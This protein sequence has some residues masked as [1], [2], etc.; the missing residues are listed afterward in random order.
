MAALA[1][2]DAFAYIYDQAG[3]PAPDVLVVLKRV[4]DASGNPILLGPKTT[5]TDSAGA[6][7]FTLPELGTAFIS[8]RA[9]A[10]WNCP[11]GRAF[12]VPPGPSGEL[13]PDFSLPASTLVEPPL[14][15]VGDVLSIPKASATQDGYLSAADFAAFEAGGS[16]MGVTQINTGAGLTGGPI[17]DSGTIGMQPISGVAGDWLNPTRISI[18]AYGQIVAITATA[19]TTAPNIT[20]ILATVTGTS[21][22]ITWTTDDLSDSQVAYSTDMSYGTSTTIDPTL[23]QSHSVTISSLIASQGYHYVVK[24]RNTATL[25]RVSPDN[26]FTTG[27]VADTT[28]PVITLA[29][30]PVTA[31]LETSAI[32]NWT[33]SENAD[34]EVRYSVDTSY[35]TATVPPITNTPVSTA[36]VTTHA[37][38]LTGLVG[39]QFYHYQVKSKDAA[40]NP[41]IPVTGTFTTAAPPPDLLTGLIS[42]WKMDETG[43]STARLDFAPAAHHNDLVPVSAI[44][45]GTGKISNAAHFTSSADH[46]LATSNTSL[47]TG[48]IDYTMALWVNLDSKATEQ[49]FWSKTGGGADEYGVGYTISGDRISSFVRGGST[50]STLNA[51]SLGSPATGQWYFIV[52]WHNNAANSI[53]IQVNDGP[54]DTFTPVPPL[55]TSDAADVFFGCYAGDIQLAT[56]LVDEAAFWKGRI[57]TAGER[58]ALYAGGAGLPFSSWT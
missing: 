35:G 3:D 50:Y 54:V 17:T 19:D 27:A 23:T 55:G 41:A 13:V 42:M 52:F 12:T 45:S 38:S 5:L 43:T 36:G 10:L 14:V 47:Q 16:D 20:A 18:N 11:D 46:L 4:L 7:H 33:T 25:L 29:V 57:L 56:G 44:G 8:A 49:K 24:S 6:F 34:S 58:T 2:C 22:T 48:P 30:P 26:T 1:Q 51:D 31:I 32:I 9:S 39:S 15:Y 53:N 37:V 21:V 28:P 40:G